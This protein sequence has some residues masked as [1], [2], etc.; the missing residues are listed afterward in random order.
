[1]TGE[2][3]W[4]T[5]VFILGGAL[6]VFVLGWWASRASK[7]GGHRHYES[8]RVVCPASGQLL[9]ATLVRENGSGAWVRVAR[10]QAFAD[11]EKIRCHEGCVDELNE[12]RETIRV[13]D[14][15]AAS[16]AQPRG[17]QRP[18]RVE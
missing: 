3:H 15:S 11:P 7:A 14:P 5:L 8:R 12:R 1:M 17:T 2:S 10:C 13:A 9:D 4:L 18:D 16:A 6:M